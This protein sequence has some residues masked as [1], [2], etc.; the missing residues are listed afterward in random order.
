LKVHDTSTTT[1]PSTSNLLVTFSN[2][3]VTVNPNGPLAV[4]PNLNGNYTTSWNGTA[5][6]FSAVSF[7]VVFSTANSPVPGFTINYQVSGVLNTNLFFL[8]V[9]FFVFFVVD[10]FF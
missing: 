5:L 9:C 10:L 2:S 3:T 4:L 7:A 6:R 8:F 1:Q